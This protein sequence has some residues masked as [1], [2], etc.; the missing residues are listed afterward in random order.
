M[1]VLNSLFKRSCFEPVEPAV[2]R[3][4][5]HTVPLRTL[6][7]CNAVLHAIAISKP[8]CRIIF[9]TVLG[10]PLKFLNRDLVGM[11]HS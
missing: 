2:D 9:S 5:L 11:I 6:G 10:C 4:S 1:I 3:S 8:L 7:L